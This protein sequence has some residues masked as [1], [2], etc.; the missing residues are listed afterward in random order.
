ME[1]DPEIF[2]KA[3]YMIGID[4]EKCIVF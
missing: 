2:L 4:P 3:G 1:K